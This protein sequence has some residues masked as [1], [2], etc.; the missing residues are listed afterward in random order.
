MLLAWMLAQFGLFTVARRCDSD[1]LRDSSVSVGDS[2]GGEVVR[3]WRVFLA[4]WTNGHMDYDDHQWA[5]LPL[6]KGSMIVYVTL[7]AMMYMQFRY[8]VLVYMGMYMYFWQNPAPETGEIC[9]PSIGLL[10]W[11]NI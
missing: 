7:V 2:L 6:L 10:F 11:F 5:L 9:H 8:R 4:T 1:W 3:L